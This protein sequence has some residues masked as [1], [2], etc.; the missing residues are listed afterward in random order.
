M[1]KQPCWSNSFFKIIGDHLVST[2]I[3]L[4]T[5]S[6]LI[7][8]RWPFKYQQMIVRFIYWLTFTDN[9]FKTVIT[10]LAY[11]LCIET[12]NIL[13]LWIFRVLPILMHIE[14]YKK[15]ITFLLNPYFNNELPSLGHCQKK[16]I[17]SE[18]TTS[19]YKEVLRKIQNV[20]IISRAL[21]GTE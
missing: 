16:F 12:D 10:C 14:V 4:S 3:W 15:N 2:V 6:H 7:F 18:R 9:R 20:P 13:N 21:A 19:Y 5:D 1:Q 17:K 8:Q 11:Q